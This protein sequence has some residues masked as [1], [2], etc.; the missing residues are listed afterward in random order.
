M[1]EVSSKFVTLVLLKNPP[2]GAKATVVVPRSTKRYSAPTDQF[3]PI[4]YSTPAP[5]VQPTFV[6]L[7][8]APRHV[9]GG[10]VTT[11]QFVPGASTSTTVCLTSPTA[12]PPVA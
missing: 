4:A 11:R 6:S 8:L 10:A 2:V 7:T 9:V 1:C 3:D 5:A 12:R